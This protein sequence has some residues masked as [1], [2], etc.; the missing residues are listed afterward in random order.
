MRPENEAKVT[1]ADD[2]RIMQKN[3]DI[4]DRE[5]VL[6]EWK[7]LPRVP[8]TVYRNKPFSLANIEMPVSV[9]KLRREQSEHTRIMMLQRAPCPFAEGSTRIAYYGLLS[10]PGSAAPSPMI[11][12]SFKFMGL[13]VNDRKHYLRQMEVS[14]LARFLAN[15]FND[16]SARPPQC[17]FVRV[18]P[19]CVI[20]EDDTKN[21]E[22]GLR[23]FCAEPPLPVGAGC[24][25]FTRFSSNTGYWAETELSQ[26]LLAFCKYTH[27]VTKGYLIVTDLQGVKCGHDF[28]LTDPVILCK[29]PLRFGSTNVGTDFMKR[30]IGST[31]KY[32]EWNGWM[33]F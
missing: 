22:T 10:K 3:Y 27:D 26:T 18:L 7:E 20:E 24:S 14:N 21:E 23:R 13:S 31:N 33:T 2:N 12:K 9:G 29:N 25:K 6:D 30:C 1:G 16:S 11:L 19:V 32:L 17:G 28:F 8:V 4:I 5:L 15:S